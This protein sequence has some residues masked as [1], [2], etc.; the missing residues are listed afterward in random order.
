MAF[1]LQ[2]KAA[3]K[4]VGNK[5]VLVKEDQKKILITD[6]VGNLIENI[7]MKN[8]YCELIKE[9]VLFLYKNNGD[10]AGSLLKLLELFLFQVQS[11]N[12]FKFS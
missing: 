7:G 12:L 1:L 11:L 2:V 9:R 8:V 5:V 4:F 3:E 6:N 10:D